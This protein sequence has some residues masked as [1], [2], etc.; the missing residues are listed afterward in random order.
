MSGYFF[1]AIS[2]KE[3]KTLFQYDISLVDPIA[4]QLANEGI[5]VGVNFN[6]EFWPY[7]EYGEENEMSVASYVDREGIAP[8]SVS[9]KEIIKD[10]YFSNA[11][12]EIGAGL[13]KSYRINLASN[14]AAKGID[15]YYKNGTRTVVKGEKTNTYDRYDIIVATENASVI[16][17]IDSIVNA[18]GSVYISAYRT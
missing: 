4:Q 18:G 3:L 9:S 1:N 15:I 2:Y 10:K 5:N 16:S 8:Y 13:S 7:S 6:T 11:Y 14:Y 17:Q 12:H